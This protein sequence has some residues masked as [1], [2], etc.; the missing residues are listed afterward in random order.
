MATWIKQTVFFNGRS[1]YIP[2]RVIGTWSSR[3]HLEA[4]GKV[5]TGPC[6]PRRGD[7]YTPLTA[8]M[9]LLDLFSL[10]LRSVMPVKGRGYPAERRQGD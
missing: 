6:S 1:C 2:P 4:P 7:S 9:C 8:L 5:R 10:A 3:D